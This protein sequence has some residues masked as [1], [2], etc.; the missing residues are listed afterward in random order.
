MLGPATKDC[1][2]QTV[3]NTSKIGLQVVLLKDGLGITQNTLQ[4]IFQDGAFQP[5]TLNLCL[6]SPFL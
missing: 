5:T 2:K 4:E 3:L 1:L 6:S